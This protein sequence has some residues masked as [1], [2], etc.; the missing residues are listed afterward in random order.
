[1]SRSATRARDAGPVDPADRAR[2]FTVHL[3]E[4][5]TAGRTH[6]VSAAGLRGRVTHVASGDSA[7]FD[8]GDELVAILV[9]VHHGRTE[10]R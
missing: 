6:D 10:V 1:M 5:G 9:R 8:S 3:R 7:H 4:A 2:V